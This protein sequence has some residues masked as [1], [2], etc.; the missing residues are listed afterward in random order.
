MEGAGLGWVSIAAL[1]GTDEQG[2]VQVQA[3]CRVQRLR[4]WASKGVQ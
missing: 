1:R 4:E 3:E 2:R